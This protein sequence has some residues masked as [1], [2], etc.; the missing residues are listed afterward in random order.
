MKFLR[1]GVRIMLTFLIG[2]YVLLL[3]LAIFS[4]RLIFQPHPAG[5]DLETLG[6]SAP[7]LQTFRIPCEFGTIAAAYL[8]NPEARDTLIYS[9]GN[10]EDMGDDLPI[11]EEY[12]R[13]GFAVFAYDYNGYGASGGRPSEAAVY[14]DAEAA[15]DFLTGPL[16]VPPERVIAFGHS[17]G[18]AASIHLAASRPVAG[19]IAQ[20]PFLSAFRVLTRIQIVPW[21]KLNNARNI[22]RVHCPVLIAQGRNDEVIPFWHGERIYALANPPKEQIW[23]EGAGHN[24]VMLVASRPFLA[25]LQNFAAGLQAGN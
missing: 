25:A 23:L 21:D 15:F 2:V 18:A 8:P 7:G 16:Q 5:Y 10:G 14:R 9:H 1:T 12:R 6:R 3:V 4:D 19:L 22:R 11:L 13:A 24:D 17:L 20:S